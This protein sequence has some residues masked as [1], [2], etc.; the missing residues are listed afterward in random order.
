MLMNDWCRHLERITFSSFTF[1]KDIKL[2]TCSWLCFKFRRK[3]FDEWVKFYN[4]SIGCLV[5]WTWL[6]RFYCEHQYLWEKKF[7]LCLVGLYMF[8]RVEWS[9]L[10]FNTRAFP[11][12]RKVDNHKLVSK[13]LVISGACVWYN[14]GDRGYPCCLDYLSS[15]L[16]ICVC[17]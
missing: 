12:R 11:L 1:S 6:G 2:V 14:L 15:S 13:M 7:D 4:T 16:K 8:I 9:I 17:C 3:S 10:P 5:H